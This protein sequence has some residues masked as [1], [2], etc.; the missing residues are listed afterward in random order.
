MLCRPAVLLG[1]GVGAI[2]RV[3]PALYSIKNNAM[4]YAI[5]QLTKMVPMVQPAVLEIIPLSGWM[6]ADP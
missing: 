5:N 1:D 6:T 4:L 2:H 3:H